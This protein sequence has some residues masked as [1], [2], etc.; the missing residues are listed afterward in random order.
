MSISTN[1]PVLLGRDYRPKL[2][3]F[4]VVTK[5]P[6]DMPEWP[7]VA[8]LWEA[9]KPTATYYRSHSLGALRGILR[10]NEG[11]QLCIDRDPLDDPVI[12]ETWV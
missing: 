4:W 9:G 1:Q 8:R 11:C 10:R 2:L 5:A 3:V 6:S 7:F 12:E